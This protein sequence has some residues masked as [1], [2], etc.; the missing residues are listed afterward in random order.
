ML[1]QRLRKNI[2][3]I[4]PLRVGMAYSIDAEYESYCIDKEDQEPIKGYLL[5]VPSMK[6]CVTEID[7]TD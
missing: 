1:F 5:K 2:L 7:D 3:T 6:S 4:E